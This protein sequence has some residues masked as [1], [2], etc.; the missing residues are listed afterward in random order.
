MDRPIKC[1]QWL[2]ASCLIPY[3]VKTSQV[4]VNG[5]ESREICY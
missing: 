1:G 5:Q 4:S 2:I 3:S